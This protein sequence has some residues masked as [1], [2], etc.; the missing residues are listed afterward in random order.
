MQSSIFKAGSAKILPLVGDDIL[1]LNQTCEVKP[2]FLL[3]MLGEK[4][5]YGI[6]EILDEICGEIRHQLYQQ[7]IQYEPFIH[8]LLESSLGWDGKDL[9]PVSPGVPSAIPISTQGQN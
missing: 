5:E 7:E 8:L 9:W 3:T 6:L 2:S 4:R 1:R